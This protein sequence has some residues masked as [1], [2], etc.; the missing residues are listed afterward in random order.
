[1]CCCGPLYLDVINWYLKL[2]MLHVKTLAL[3]AG[4]VRLT[5]S[6]TASHNPISTGIFSFGASV[7]PHY[8]LLTYLKVWE[9]SI[10]RRIT[11]HFTSDKNDRHAIYTGWGIK[12]SDFSKGY[13][14]WKK[15][16]RKKIKYICE[17]YIK[18]VF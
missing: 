10:I 1:M 11:R 18:R 14:I 16:S 7:F 6:Q 13:K 3:T 8:K 4:Q 9:T 5:F 12:I 2:E 15:L 17:K